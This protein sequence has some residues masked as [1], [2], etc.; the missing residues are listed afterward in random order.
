MQWCSGCELYAYQNTNSGNIP[1]NLHLDSLL[2]IY[3][4][5]SAAELHFNWSRDRPWPPNLLKS[6]P[7]L[8]NHVAWQ[9]QMQLMLQDMQNN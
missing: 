6:K 8:N 5:I 3:A 1:G 2:N 4:S 7:I 9:P